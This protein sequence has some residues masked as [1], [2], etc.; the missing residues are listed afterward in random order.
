MGK[1]RIQDR[2]ELDIKTE[3]CLFGSLS[4]TVKEA[5]WENER[6]ENKAWKKP[7]LKRSNKKRRQKELS[8]KRT[9]RMK[10]E[11]MSGRSA[12]SGTK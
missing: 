6:P 1:Q 11:R 9:L 3:E 5:G 7:P 4:E 10:E 2:S 8:T 12:L